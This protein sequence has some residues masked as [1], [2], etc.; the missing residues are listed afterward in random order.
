MYTRACVRACVRACLLV[1][2]VLGGRTHGAGQGVGGAVHGREGPGGEGPGQEQSP[3]AVG[4]VHKV[5]ARRQLGLQVLT[6]GGGESGSVP[7]W[8]Q[9]ECLE[10]QPVTDTSLQRPP[11]S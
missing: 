8:T 11:S 6:G 5:P 2:V 10:Q 4:V 9:S 3:A 7:V 1:P